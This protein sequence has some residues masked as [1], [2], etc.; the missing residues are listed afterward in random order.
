MK[1]RDFD[2]YVNMIPTISI[3]RENVPKT[4]KI[5]KIVRLSETKEFCREGIKISKS[6]NTKI[7]K[8]L[9]SDDKPLLSKFIN[10]TFLRVRQVAVSKLKML[11]HLKTTFPRR[12]TSKSQKSLSH[13]ISFLSHFKK[14]CLTL[15]YTNKY[16]N[17]EINDSSHSS[18]IPVSSQKIH[19][20][21][22]F[23]H[24][25]LAWLNRHSPIAFR[26]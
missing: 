14:A 13:L 16:I 11:I 21:K 24:P 20:E 8:N 26:A 3:P 7:P 9:F 2:G 19:C 25:C 12:Q 4:V 15:T 23:G 6:Q 22:L 5:P 10:L 1:I 17:S 18:L